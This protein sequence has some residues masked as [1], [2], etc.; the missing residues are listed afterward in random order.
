M[1][2]W[3]LKPGAGKIKTGHPWVYA[4]EL[5]SVSKNHAPAIIVELQDD[6]GQFVARGYGNPESQ[7]T[8]RAVSF[9]SAE[10]SPLSFEAIIKKLLSA[11]RLRWQMGFRGSFRLC[12]GEG[13]YLPGLIVDY[14][15]VEQ[16]GQTAQVFAVQ[17]LTAGM[18]VALRG[19]EKLFENLVDQASKVGLTS[20]D[21]TASA[22]VLRNDVNVRKFEGLEVEHP[23]FI[24]SIREFNFEKIDILLNAAQDS[25]LVKMSCDLFK[26]QKTGFFLDQTH[27]IFMVTHFLKQNPH[28]LKGKSKIK[29]LDLCCY[30]GHWSTQLA[31]LL[32]SMGCDVEVCL[33][34]VSKSALEF[35]KFNSEREGAKAECLSLDVLDGLGK[36][37]SQGYDIV[38]ADPPAFIKA[39]KDIPTGRHAYLK[40]NA[41][42]FRIVKKGGLVVSCS[43]SGSLSEEDFR[44]ALRRAAQRNELNVRNMTRGG[45]AADHPTLMQFPE[46]FYLKMYLQFVGTEGS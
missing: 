31:R 29:I 5:Q 36:L 28:W 27:N 45:H 46:G 39:K 37:E 18:D 30:V 16:N 9:S 40:M 17:I 34:D 10:K 2:T 26:G 43:C 15:L 8:F 44:E 13:D 22:V 41:Q 33:V 25:G 6:K 23:R 3:R 11:W 42:A 19:C 35:A 7:I 20:H 24:K 14:Y 32:K 1:T 4:Q 38:I 12:F 21:W